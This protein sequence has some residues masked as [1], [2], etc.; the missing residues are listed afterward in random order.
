MSAAA[1]GAKPNELIMSIFGNDYEINHF[2]AYY[3]IYPI[4]IDALYSAAEET[5]KINFRYS[6]MDYDPI[7]GIDDLSAAIVKKIA[8]D[9]Q[10]SYVDGVNYLYVLLKKE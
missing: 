2:E 6:G 1:N 4:S 8:E 10:Y 7:E 5:V 9:V 3:N